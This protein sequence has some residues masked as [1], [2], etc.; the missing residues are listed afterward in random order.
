[1]RDA[2][3]VGWVRVAPPRL[4]LPPAPLLLFRLRA[5]LVRDPLEP[6]ETAEDTDWPEEGGGMTLVGLYAVF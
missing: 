4:E 2:K 5:E 3:F 1:M 6:I